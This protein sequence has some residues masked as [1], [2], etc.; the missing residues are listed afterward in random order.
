MAEGVTGLGFRAWGRIRGLVE[1]WRAWGLGRGHKVPST[2]NLIPINPL[3]S[4]P[5]GCKFCRAKAQ[6]EAT[7][8]SQP[9]PYI[10][11][12]NRLGFLSVGCPITGPKA[13][14]QT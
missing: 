1:T 12:I 7:Q 2:V 9:E 10:T 14:P 4:S 8:I 6:T 11:R 5:G 3:P 13:H